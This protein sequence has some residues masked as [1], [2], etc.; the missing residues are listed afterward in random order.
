MCGTS[1]TRE[2]SLP[3]AIYSLVDIF[4]DPETQGKH[5]RGRFRLLWPLCPLTRTNP[6]IHLPHHPAGSFIILFF[7]RPWFIEEKAKHNR[8]FPF[9]LAAF[10][11]SFSPWVAKVTIGQTLQHLFCKMLQKGAC[12]ITSKEVS[13]EWEPHT[14]GFFSRTQK[15]GHPTW[16]P[17]WPWEWKGWSYNFRVVFNKWRPRR[18]LEKSNLVLRSFVRWVGKRTIFSIYISCYEQLFFSLENCESGVDTHDGNARGACCMFPFTF[19]GKEYHSCTSDGVTLKGKWCATTGNFTRD[20]KWGL[21]F[22]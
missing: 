9:L 17:H 6:E 4:W 5:R 14:A 1:F 20:N 15:L 2:I 19:R 7:I 21:C 13:F 12:D 11:N 8:N 3:H 10:L 18:K 22:N 16:L